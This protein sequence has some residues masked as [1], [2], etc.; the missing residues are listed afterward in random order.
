MIEEL[1]M[2]VFEVPKTDPSVFS[3][4]K[5]TDKKSFHH[6]KILTDADWAIFRERFEEHFPGFIRRVKTRFSEFTPA[7]TRLFL[8]IKLGFETRE[9]AAVLGIATGSI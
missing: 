8:L 6:L 5:T 4:E 9:I 1:K 7:E 3:H 2:Q